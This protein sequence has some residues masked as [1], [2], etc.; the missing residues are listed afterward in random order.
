M[1]RRALPV[2]SFGSEIMA[3]LLAA[4]KPPGLVVPFDSLDMAMRFR[5]RLYSLRAAM[6]RESHPSTSIAMSV[7]IYVERNPPSIR[8]A[9]A[10]SEFAAAIA[11]AGIPTVPGPS[12]FDRRFDDLLRDLSDDG[13]E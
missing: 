8:L 12:S 13:V 4:A 6:S 1:P 11:K 7:R 9:P 3:A 10:D 5:Q 2:S